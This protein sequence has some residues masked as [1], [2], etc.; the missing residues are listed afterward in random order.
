MQSSLYLLSFTAISLGFIHTI[1]G[2]DH[3]VPFIAISKARQWNIW[4]TYLISF[5]CGLGHVLSS[6]ILGCIGIFL[7]ITV[8]KLEWIEGVRGDVAA[9]FLLV[10][11][12]LY[13]IYGIKQIFRGKIHTHLHTYGEDGVV[14]KHAHNHV[15]KHMHVYDNLVQPNI[16]PWVLFIIFVFGPCEPLI[17]IL[18]YPAL[19]HNILDVVVVSF[20]FSVV[21]ITTMLIMITIGYFGLS[22]FKLNVLQKYSHALAGSAIICCAIFIFLGL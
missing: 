20:L 4:K 16:T 13:T 15:N 10:F 17:P 6:V 1:L 3:Y 22:F 14:H 8:Q 7:G 18:M 19:Q 5:L 2:P 11:G 12:I 9:W 21:T